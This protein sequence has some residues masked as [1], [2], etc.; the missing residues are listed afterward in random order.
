MIL[1]SILILLASIML[2]DSAMALSCMRPDIAKTMEKAKASETVYHIL[3]GNFT[4]HAPVPRFQGSDPRDQFEQKPPII[5][6]ALFTGHSLAKTPHLDERLTRFPI[7]I[8]TSCMGPWCGSL[9]PQQTPYIAFV[10]ARPGQVPILR[11]SPCQDVMYPADEGGQKVSKL[12]TC[13]DGLC[14]S[15][16]EPY[17]R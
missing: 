1:R 4:S 14:R 16:Q 11:L 3:V 7:A 17:D 15:D 9:P 6:R 5:T 13:F 8:E 10:E 12:R 2:S